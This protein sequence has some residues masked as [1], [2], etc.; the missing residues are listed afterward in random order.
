[1]SLPLTFCTFPLPPVHFQLL[2]SL[3]TSLSTSSFPFLLPTFTSLSTSR[4]HSMLLLSAFTSYFLFPLPYPASTSCTHFHFLL[5]FLASTSN[6]HSLLWL[7][8][9]VSHFGSHLC[10][11]SLL[12]HPTILLFTS[13]FSTFRPLPFPTFPLS[14]SISTLTSTFHFNCPLPLLTSTPTTISAFHFYILLPHPTLTSDSAPHASVN[15]SV[16]GSKQKLQ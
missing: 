5:T 2:F 14:S 6:F 7:P 10:S 11:L 9:S 4:F 12:P 13:Q 15:R 1:M 16:R 3:S 8:T